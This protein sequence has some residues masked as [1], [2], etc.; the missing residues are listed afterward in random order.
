MEIKQF[1][2]IKICLTLVSATFFLGSCT[3]EDIKTAE[4]F[5]LL[6]AELSAANTRISADIYGSC[7]RW[8][9]LFGNDTPRSRSQMQTVIKDC[10]EY[11]QNAEKAKLA[12]GILIGYVKAI[13]ELA[14]EDSA[15]FNQ[16]FA[17]I[18]ESL[19]SLAFDKNVPTPT[20]EDPNKISTIKVKFNDSAVKAG[21]KIAEF[22]TNLIIRDFR[23]ENLKTAIVCTSDSIEEY[24][25][26]LAS[27][28]EDHYVNYL[29]DREI[30]KL[31]EV[32]GYDKAEDQ[33][34]KKEIQDIVELKKGGS[35]YVILIQSTAQF[36]NRLK[37]I[38]N[39]D[40]NELS[41]EQ[42]KECD[43]YFAF[44]SSPSYLSNQA[45]SL[46]ELDRASKALDNYINEISPLL[47]QINKKSK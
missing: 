43:E 28:F 45:I 4:K 38:F 32:R 39:D 2:R 11:R 21:V 22:I 5:G 23:R 15:G 42:N 13:G 12:G 29:L 44:N 36:H 10:D 7:T 6:S 25:E 24:S 40:Q 8:A 3:N 41:I 18:E 35:A 47:A 26:E 30:D 16:R 17:E 9:I 46:N 33:L 1:F 20:A 37:L 27:F 14:T 31:A 34:L 19:N